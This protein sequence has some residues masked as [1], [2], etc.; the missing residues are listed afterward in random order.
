MRAVTASTSLSTV[1]EIRAVMAETRLVACAMT[2]G[3]AVP[4]DTTSVLA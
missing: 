4:S 3:V 2:Y 1:P